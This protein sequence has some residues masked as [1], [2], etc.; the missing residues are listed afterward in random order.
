VKLR[1]SVP[2]WLRIAAKIVLARLPVRYGLWKQLR[3]F[4]HGDMD[5]PQRAI[6]TFVTHARTAGVLADGHPPRLAVPREG[7]FA[8][9][10]LGPGDALFT[11][12]IAS[13]MGA[14]KT[15]LVDAGAF[16]TRDRAA[17]GALN[18]RLTALGYR[19]ESVGH[20]HAGED[21]LL[22]PYGGRYLTQGTQSL[23]GIPDASVDFCFSN[24]VLEHVP[25]GEF[26]WMMRELARI[27][28]PEGVSVHR[29]DLKDHLGGGLNNLRFSNE[30]WEGALFRRSGFYTNRIRFQSMLSMFDAAGFDHQLARV[31]RWERL[32]IARS[33]LAQPFRQLSDDDLLVSGFDVVLRRRA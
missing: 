11:A 6:D 24:A 5:E 26:A 9:L 31:V 4:Q 16:A 15:W 22:D 28:K 23:V 18:A 1:N 7:G 21:P 17:Y 12:A 10:E 32:P 29:V 27:L 13:A 2:W 14:D 20:A 8:V 3:L 19:S 25:Q 33:A 30:T